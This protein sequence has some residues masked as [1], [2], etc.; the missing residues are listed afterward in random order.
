MTLETAVGSVLAAGI[1]ISIFFILLYFAPTITAML[2]K[3]PNIISI[4][5]VNFLLGWTFIGWAIA[6]IWAFRVSNPEKIIIEKN[7]IDDRSPLV[8]LQERYAKG[9]ITE[10]EYKKMKSKIDN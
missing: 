1:L 3:N 6:L 9:E 4:F 7:K 5:L 2:R 10:T 8:L